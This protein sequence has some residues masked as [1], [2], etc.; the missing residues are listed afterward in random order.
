MKTTRLLLPFT[1]GVD[2]DVLEY[3]VL[4]AKNRNATLI[5]LALIYVPESLRS[6]GARLEHIQQAKDFLEA[7]RHKAA[8]HS[9]SVERFEVFTSDVVQSIDVLVRQMEC[10]GILLFARGGDGIL[11]SAEEVEQIMKKIDCKLYIMHLPPKENKKFLRMLF[12]H[13]SNWLPRRQKRQDKQ[14]LAQEIPE[15]KVRQESAL[16]TH[17]SP[18]DHE[19]AAIH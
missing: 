13:L 3:A 8:K 2:L 1:H 9:V 16:S 6:K 19:R 7:M 10:E 12:S 5:P 18:H 14:L 17:A 11:L 15:E 4:L